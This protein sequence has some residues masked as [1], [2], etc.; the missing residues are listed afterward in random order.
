MQSKTISIVIPIYNEAPNVTPLYKTLTSIIRSLPH[1]FELIFV[2]DGSS[3]DSVKKLRQ[4]ARK[5]KRAKVIELAR[6]FGKEIAVTAGLHKAKGDAAII[7][8]A[9]LQHPPELLPQFV[10]EWEKG[11]DVVVGVKKYSKDESWFKKVSSSGF[12]AILGKVTSAT[13]TPHA[14][15]FRLINRKVI[16]TFKTFTERNRITRG[17]IDWA[18]FDRRYI[19]FEAPPRLH[20][21]A[22]YSYRKLFGLAMNSFTAY[23]ML[24]LK[25]ASWLGWII[26][27][28][29]S[30]LGAFVMVEKYILGDPMQLEVRGTA[31]LAILLLFLIGVVLI[32]LGFVALYIARI[33]EEVI[34]RPL[35]IVKNEENGD[36]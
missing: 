13:I 17:L 35:Y 33:H 1:Q 25:V 36:A 18:G 19:Y 29:S 2:D 16:D 10:N 23:S 3:D 32:C 20:G 15:D 31:L 4:V 28:V 11:A 6:N 30:A 7:M 9:D 14:S 22:G 5:D 21:E 34:N 8:D 12:Y 24:P 26:L 27:V